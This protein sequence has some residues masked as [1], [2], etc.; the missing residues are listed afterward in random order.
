MISPPDSR[1]RLLD[2][3]RDLIYSRSYSEVG[4]QAICDHAGVRKG[5]FYH[6]FPSKRELTLAVLD[7]FLVDFKQDLFGRAFASDL[8][9]MQRFA[10][11]TDLVYSFQKEITRVTGRVLGCPFGNLAVEMS[12]QDE[13][14]R[15]RVETIFRSLQEYFL[16]TLEEALATNQIDPVD[17]GE[18]AQAMFAFMEGILLMA[19]T[20]NDP[21]VIR[22]FGP[23]LADIRIALH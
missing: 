12:T 2:S 4:V 3:A 22:Q 8:P 7:E 9:P 19:K 5:S 15:Q 6:F 10:R 14:I 18:T 16:E 17:P 1:Q 20:Q 21:E 23:A 11:L 13:T